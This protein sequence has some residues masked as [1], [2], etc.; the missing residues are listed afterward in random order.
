MRREERVSVQGPVKDQQPDGVSH[1]GY[2]PLDPPNKVTIVGKNE[3]YDR[4]AL[5]GPFLGHKIL[6]PRPPLPLLTPPCPCPPVLISLPAPSVSAGPRQR[7]G[8]L[9]GPGAGGARD[10][11]VP[12]L[13]PL[14]ADVDHGPQRSVP[15]HRRRDVVGRRLR[16]ARD[17][18]DHHADHTGLGHDPATGSRSPP[19]PPPR[20]TA[21][22]AE[23]TL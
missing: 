3:I 16:D 21:D 14:G 10:A 23:G 18:G 22:W 17:G 15:R 4:E 1:R 7:H 2:P 12:P 13:F 6:D 19:P 5:V 9:E 20:P 8:V 11:A